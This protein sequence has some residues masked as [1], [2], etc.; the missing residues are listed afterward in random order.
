MQRITAAMP[1]P[2]KAAASA[3]SAES[4]RSAAPYEEARTPPR[5]NTANLTLQ[6][7]DGLALTTG[8]LTD[9]PLTSTPMVKQHRRSIDGSAGGGGDGGASGSDG[10]DGRQSR[11]GI[12]PLPDEWEELVDQETKHRFFANHVTRETS[13][14]DPRDRVSLALCHSLCFTTL[15]TKTSCS[16]R[17]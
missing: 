2:T 17:T 4:T 3:A 1:S 14:T 5:D 10:G 8:S 15:T 16:S 7:Q 6:L 11:P 13:W 12:E 9:L